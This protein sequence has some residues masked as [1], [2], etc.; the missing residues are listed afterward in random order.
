MSYPVELQVSELSDFASLM[1]TK[2]LSTWKVLVS[3]A[4]VLVKVWQMR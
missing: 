3:I 4:I 1:Q 2:S